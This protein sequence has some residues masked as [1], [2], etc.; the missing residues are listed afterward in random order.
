MAIRVLATR[1][2]RVTCITTL[3]TPAVYFAM[4]FFGV[5][6]SQVTMMVNKGHHQSTQWAPEKNISFKGNGVATRVPPGG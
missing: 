2:V 1:N 4:L 5:G 3:S 6:A